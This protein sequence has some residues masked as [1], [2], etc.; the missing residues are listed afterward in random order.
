MRCHAR[1]QKLHFSFMF[2]P[3]QLTRGFCAALCVASYLWNISFLHMHWILGG[4]LILPLTCA[5]CTVLLLP[6]LVAMIWCNCNNI[7]KSNSKCGLIRKCSSRCGWECYQLTKGWRIT[8]DCM[9]SFNPSKD[10]KCNRNAS[11]CWRITLNPSALRTIA[12]AIPGRVEW[13]WM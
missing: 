5:R 4:H 10:Y 7:P 8:K 12:F 9:W 11:K 1:S 2:A 13:L 6:W 3:W